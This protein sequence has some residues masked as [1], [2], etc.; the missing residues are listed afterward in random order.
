MSTFSKEINHKANKLG[1][2]VVFLRVIDGRKVKRFKSSVELRSPRDWNK[3]KQEV[4]ASNP[5]HKVLNS[6]LEAE[7]AQLKYDYLHTQATGDMAKEDFI[8][9]VAELHKEDVSPSFISYLQQRVQDLFDAGDFASYKKY[10]GFYNKLVAFQTKNGKVVDLSFNDLTTSYISRFHAYLRTLPNE[11]NPEKVLHPNT[12]EVVLN[13]FKACVKRAIE[14]DKIIPYEKNPFLGYK[15]SGV[16]TFKEKLDEQEISLIVSLD[17]EEGSLIWNCRNYFLFSLYCAGIRVGD[18]LQLRWSN[19]TNNGQRLVYEMGKNHK[20]RD[21]VLVPQ[22]QQIL[23][24][25]NKVDHSSSDYIFPLLDSRA[26][27]AKA[28][29]QAEK[30]VQTNNLKHERFRQISAKTALINKE[31]KLI[32]ELA[33]LSKHLSFHIS[34]HTFARMAKERGVDNS[35]LKS[36][37]AHSSLKITEGYMGNFDTASDDRALVSIFEQLNPDDLKKRELL[38]YLSNLPLEELDGIV[39][40]Y[41]M[42][43]KS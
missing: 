40:G 11:R 32:A 14:V 5:D 9:K 8:A 34:R 1:M 41:K 29:T 43:S 13:K 28:V 24:Y 12:I 4:R 22:A 21:L 36:L 31:L 42:R 15:Y 37:L 27:W 19:I 17:L 2:Y 3:K 35:H 20:T 25:Y 23:E 10:N 39:E 18:F 6:T 30:D 7:L 38:G 33:G 26:P 16:Q